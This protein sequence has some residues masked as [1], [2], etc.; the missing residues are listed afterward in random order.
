MSPVG[1]AELT[2]EEISKYTA[3]AF[4]VLENLKI[5]QEKK[6]LLRKYGKSLMDREV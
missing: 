4:E 5:P 6:D 1:A 3:K 2:K